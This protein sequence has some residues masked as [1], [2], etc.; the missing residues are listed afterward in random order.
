MRAY[1]PNATSD[2][3]GVCLLKSLCDPEMFFLIPCP[4][5]AHVMTEEKINEFALDP[6]FL[7]NSV[8]A[9]IGI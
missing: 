8:T 6:D 7:E 4:C 1:A 2:V 5:R 3:M 9:N